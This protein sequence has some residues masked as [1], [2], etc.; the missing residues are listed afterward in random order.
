MLHQLGGLVGFYCKH[1]NQLV[2]L[3]DMSNP[4]A[5]FIFQSKMIINPLVKTSL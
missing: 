1:Y 5:L 4:A 2:K 3:I